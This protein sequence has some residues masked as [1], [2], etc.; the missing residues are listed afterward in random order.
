VNGGPSERDNMLEPTLDAAKQH[1]VKIIELKNDQGV[2][3]FFESCS[4]LVTVPH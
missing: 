4:R 2:E 1:G 3:A